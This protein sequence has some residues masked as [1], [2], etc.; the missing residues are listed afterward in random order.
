MSKFDAYRQLRYLGERFL[1][2]LE[3]NFGTPPL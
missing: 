2:K 3:V 1:P